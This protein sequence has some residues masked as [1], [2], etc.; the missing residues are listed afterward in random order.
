[1]PLEI[2]AILIGVL[3]HR[4]GKQHLDLETRQV[5]IQDRDLPFDQ[6]G[7]LEVA[8]TPP[9]GRPRHSGELRKLDLALRRIGLQRVEQAAI[10]A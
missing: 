2:V 7:L 8:N 4:Y 6:A 5:C 9:A 3:S 10:G 1:M